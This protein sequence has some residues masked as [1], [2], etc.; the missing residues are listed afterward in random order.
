VFRAGV[1]AMPDTK[2][3]GRGGERADIFLLHQTEADQQPEG[4]EEHESPWDISD[5]LEGAVPIRA[6]QDCPLSRCEE[7]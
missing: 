7:A 6:R 2:E 5:P 4:Q 3:T 1:D